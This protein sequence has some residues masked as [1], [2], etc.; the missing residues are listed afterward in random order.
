MAIVNLDKVQACYSGNLE[1][2][3]FDTDVTNGVF[4]HIG[5]LKEGLVSGDGEVVEAVVP[6][7][8]SIATQEVVL[9]ASP[10]VNYD[11]RQAGLKH[12]KLK[13]GEIGRGYHLTP[14]DMIT[15]TEDLIDG[16]P[17]V[18]EYVIPQAG[19]MKLVASKDGAGTY[20][21]A[22]VV[23]KGVLG[24]DAQTAYTIRVVNAGDVSNGEVSG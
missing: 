2:M 22:K 3:V 5:G 11:P 7:A 20:F 9:H 1:S 16:T 18:G 23:E 15:L 17:V 24:F 6:T 8:E 21:V 12:F 13:A 14:G 4:A 19:S 10:E